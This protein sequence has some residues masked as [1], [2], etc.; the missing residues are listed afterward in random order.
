MFGSCNCF[1]CFEKE[2]EEEEE[3]EEQK[4]QQ[5]QQQ[6]QEQQQQKE[7]KRRFK[8][9]F[10]NVLCCHIKI[11]VLF[12]RFRVWIL[13]WSA[14]CKPCFIYIFS[15]LQIP[16]TICQENETDLKSHHAHYQRHYRI[17]TTTTA[18]TTTTT[19]TAAVINNSNNITII[20]T[21]ITVL[22]FI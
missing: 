11:S 15:P 22:V 21:L 2:E 16:I 18:T 19:T 3:E 1:C 17:K 8:P 10:G 20:D 4:Q 9:K 6:Q 13:F 12:N 14:N 7:K 5:Q